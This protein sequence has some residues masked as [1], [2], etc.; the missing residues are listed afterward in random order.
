MASPKPPAKVSDLD[1]EAP[2]STDFANYFCTYAYIYHQKDMLEDHKRTG[3]YYQS[4]LSNKRQFQGKGSMEGWAE[5][6]Q[7]MQHYYQAPIKGEM[8]LHMTDGGPVDALCGFFDVWFKGSEENP[9]DNEIRLSTGPDP[10]GAT[11][12]GQQSF[13]LQPP[14]DCAPGDRLHIS[15]EVSRRTDNQRL[16]LVKAG[17]T[18]EGNSIYAEQSKTPRQFRWNIE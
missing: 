7:E 18:V 6:V 10:T 4:V 16:L 14:I 12:W 15:L 17:I 13:P 2:E 9:A 5:F 11:H 8:V 1:G 3:A